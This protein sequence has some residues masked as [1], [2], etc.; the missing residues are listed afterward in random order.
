M[1]VINSEKWKKKWLSLKEEVKISTR[2]K[3]KCEDWTKMNKK[4]GI[5]YKMKKKRAY[6]MREKRKRL[7]TSNQVL[8]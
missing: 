4:D 8:T 3:G 7:R 2:G 5:K 6:K 1:Q